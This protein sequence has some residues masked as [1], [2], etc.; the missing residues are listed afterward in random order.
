MVCYHR[1]LTMTI[2]ATPNSIEENAARP[3][4]DARLRPIIDKVERGERLVA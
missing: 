4:F 3:G 1:R 2:A